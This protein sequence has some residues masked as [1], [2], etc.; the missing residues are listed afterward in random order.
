MPKYPKDFEPPELLWHEGRLYGNISLKSSSISSIAY[1]EQQRE[2]KYIEL[3]DWMKYVE[4]AVEDQLYFVSNHVYEQLKK[5]I[6]EEGKLVEVEEIKVQKD[7]WEWDE[8]ESVF[9]QY[10][11]SFVRNKG[12]YL[13]ETDIY[14]FHISTKTNM[15]TILGDTRCWKI[16]F[17]ASLCRSTWITIRGRIGLDPDFT[18]I[19]RTT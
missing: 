15:L 2:C 19:S 1:F 4:I 9:L 6:T 16:T 12:L 3:N 5:R 13:D 8:R 14:N 17:C 7:E 18:I 10:V 11:K